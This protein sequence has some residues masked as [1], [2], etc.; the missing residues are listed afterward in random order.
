[1]AVVESGER[2]GV[3]LPDEGEQIPVCQELVLSP[4]TP[5]HHTHCPFVKVGKQN[6]FVSNFC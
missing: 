6:Y 5:H 4:P 3:A 2:L 1:M